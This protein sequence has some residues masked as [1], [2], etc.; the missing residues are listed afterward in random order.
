MD[1]MDDYLNNLSDGRNA[2]Y[3]PDSHT[4]R[5]VRPTKQQQSLIQDSV[6]ADMVRMRLVQEARQAE[7][8]QGMGGSYD[9]GSAA[10]KR[11]VTPPAPAPSGIPVASTNTLRVQI[12]TL[13]VDAYV[14]N[15]GSGYF[16]GDSCGPEGD[17]SSNGLFKAGQWGL[18]LPCSG[19]TLYL[20]PSTN[21]SIIPT[22]GW[23]VGGAPINIVFTVID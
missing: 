13:G 14:Y 23:T 9:A 6:V 16:N 18:E 22:T 11:P 21:G 1:W 19:G 20:N 10:K 3:P 5:P 7:I 2:V 12:P 4:W 8:D 17:Q 15:N